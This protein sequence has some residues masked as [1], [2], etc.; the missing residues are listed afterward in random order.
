MTIADLMQCDLI[1]NADYEAIIVGPEFMQWDFS[2]GDTDTI[3]QEKIYY[4][5]NLK[6]TISGTKVVLV[7]PKTGI[8]AITDPITQHI[9]L[10]PMTD[11]TF[12]IIPLDICAKQFADDLLSIEQWRVGGICR[13]GHSFRVHG[14][15]RP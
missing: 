12:Q 9:R 2:A 5:Q 14:N 11:V 6:E 4:A 3:R 13:N 10:S 7:Y 1:K 8:G 15:E